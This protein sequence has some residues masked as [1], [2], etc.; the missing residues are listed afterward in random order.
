MDKLTKIMESVFRL[1]E[2]TIKVDS[3]MADTPGW[4]SLTHINL[5]LEIE[6][7]F[8]IQLSGDDIAEMQSISKIVEIL[9]QYH[10]SS[11]NN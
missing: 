5:I 6:R 11:K 10:T 4:D 2:G 8:D 3:T 1:S 9:E 7:E